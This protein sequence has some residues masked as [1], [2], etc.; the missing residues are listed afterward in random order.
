MNNKS[1]IKHIGIS[2][3]VKPIGMLLLFAYTPLALSFLGDEKYGVWAIIL[4]IIS[5]INYFDIGIGNGL[6]NKLAESFSK[7]DDETSQSLVSTAYF[8]TG[9]ISFVF[10]IIMVII[11]NVFGLSDFFD[12]NVEGDNVNLVV[13]VSIFFVCIN[14]ILSLSKAIMY[15]IQKSG[16]ISV[17][18]VIGQ[19]LQ[20]IV[21]WIMS[22]FMKE[23]LMAIA[24]LYGCISLVDNIIL[25][26]LINRKYLFLI[27]HVK[28]INFKYFK[29]LMSLGI[30]FFVIQ[31]C[32]LVLNTTDNLLISNL[33]GAAEVTPY[34]LVYKVF[35]MFVQAHGII[36]MPMWSAYTAAI[37]QND[38]NW[39]KK[40]M[41]KIN[42]A[43]GLLSAGVVVCVFLFEPFA[44]IW[45]G[46]KLDYGKDL[47][48]IVALYMI[49]QMIYNNY[50]SFLCGAGEIKVNSILALIG[51]VINIPLSV[52]FAD[53]LKMRLAGIILG[54]LM[55]MLM[56]VAILPV[57]T[58]RWFKKH[59]I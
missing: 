24:V 16:F 10:C 18:S 26:I 21:L 38:L 39:I 32:T 35:Y 2:M 58:H 13:T 37:A 4:N 52:F 42:I 20:L 6:K 3:L 55:V 14:F 5:W 30:G 27:P 11:W 53:T 47:I 29:P 50:S 40:T 59:C 33:F 45:L 15:A 44:A 57:V 25:K 1:I 22:H 48:I 43:T 34:D 36:I 17:V 8:A 12:L 31:I 54:S 56:N 7:N 51:A 46:K 28:G 41:K 23:S 49:L 9:I 19:A